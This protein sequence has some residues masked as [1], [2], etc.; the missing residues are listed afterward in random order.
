VGGCHVIEARQDLL[1]RTDGA[2][3]IF[4]GAGLD[5]GEIPVPVAAALPPMLL[6]GGRQDRAGIGV[7]EFGG[8]GG[9]LAG[10]VVEADQ[11]TMPRTVWTPDVFD[12]VGDR[13]VI[14]FAVVGAVPQH[15]FSTTD[16]D[17]GVRGV[18]E[19]GNQVRADIA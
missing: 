2:T 7:Y 5:A 14:R 19:L 18:D 1:V 6:G 9:V 15:S 11:N 13:L 12:P 8:Y 17:G 4:A 16:A 10:E 3:H